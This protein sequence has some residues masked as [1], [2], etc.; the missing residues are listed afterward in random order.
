MRKQLF[1][2]F[3][4]VLAWSGGTTLIRG[5]QKFDPNHPIVQER[6]DLFRSAE[7]EDDAAETR[8]AAEGQRQVETTMQHPAGA[9]ATNRVP[10]G[11]SGQ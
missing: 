11:G 3:E 5:G 6:P 7:D 4:G 1:S 2:N 10:K 8:S 9:R